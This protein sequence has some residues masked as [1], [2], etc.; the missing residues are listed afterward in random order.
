MET[1]DAPNMMTIKCCP[2]CRSR[3]IYRRKNQRGFY[4]QSCKFS[5]PIPSTKQVADHRNGLSIPKGLLPHV[6]S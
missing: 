3:D 4:C 6:K 1:T 2:A 5:F